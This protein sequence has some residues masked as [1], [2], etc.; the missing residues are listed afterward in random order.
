[1]RKLLYYGCQ[2]VVFFEDLVTN[3][4]ERAREKTI[5]VGEFHKV[6][7]WNWKLYKTLLFS[8]IQNEAVYEL[9]KPRGDVLS[10][11]FRPIARENEPS[12]RP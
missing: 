1:M 8:I 10:L 3:Q 9:T 12:P 6:Y 7:W 5:L 2:V 4:E 11:N